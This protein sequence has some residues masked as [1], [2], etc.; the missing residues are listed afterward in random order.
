[1]LKRVKEIFIFH[2]KANNENI[3]YNPCF[4]IGMI[5]MLDGESG[6]QSCNLTEING[7]YCTDE[8]KFLNAC[9]ASAIIG[10]LQAGYTDLKYFTDVSRKIFEREAL[11]GCSITGWMDNP[12]ILFDEELQRKGKI[13]KV[14]KWV[15]KDS[16]IF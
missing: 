15:G 4:E 10:T 6:W 16:D 3:I 5:P 7:K 11:L 9:K 14:F 1:M 12:D 2:I 8:E 13:P